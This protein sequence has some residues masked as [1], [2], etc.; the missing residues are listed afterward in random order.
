MEAIIQYIST[1]ETSTKIAAV[2]AI[3]AV[4]SLLISLW[5]VFI[6]KKSMRI[7]ER[8]YED[9]QSRFEIIYQSGFRVDKM[10]NGMKVHYL[11]SQI[12]L[13]NLSSKIN[14]FKG[15]L[16]IEYIR[17]DETVC[18][19]ISNHNPK[20]IEEIGSIDFNVYD[21]NI[22]VNGKCAITKWFIFELPHIIESNYKILKFEI[23][24]KDLD[25]RSKITEALLIRKLQL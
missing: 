23:C 18:K 5:L 16:Q 17:E 1:V 20:L 11:L 10:K 15:Q 13:R 3:A 22:S 21:E 4:V 25:E 19:T 12:I 7:S 14:N 8:L 6:S 9:A 2:S 24:V